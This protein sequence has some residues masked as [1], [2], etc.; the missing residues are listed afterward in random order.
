MDLSDDYHRPKTSQKKHASIFVKE[1]SMSNSHE[2]IEPY[3]PQLMANTNEHTQRTTNPLH[4]DN[5]T[6][7]GSRIA[8]ARGFYPSTNLS[9]SSIKSTKT[10]QFLRDQTKSSRIRSQD[11]IK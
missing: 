9:Q 6:D 1:Y 3:K 10:S 7:S 4:I 2:L 5:F 11:L 8:I